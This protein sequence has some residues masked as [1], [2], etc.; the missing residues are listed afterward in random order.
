MGL[1]PPDEADGCENRRVEAQEEGVRRAPSGADPVRHF[2][3]DL[4][5]LK[6]ESRGGRILRRQFYLDRIRPQVGPDITR[7]RRGTRC[8]V[9]TKDVPRQ[10]LPP[11]RACRA[12]ETLPPPQPAR[13]ARGKGG[14]LF[15]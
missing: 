5:L 15:G 7:S 11:C 6:Q 13:V 2:H 8:E 10:H 14:F 3:V 12:R 1:A 9:A 4:V